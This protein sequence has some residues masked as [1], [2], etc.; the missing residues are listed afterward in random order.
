MVS[1]HVFVGAGLCGAADL[2]SVHLPRGYSCVLQ[3]EGACRSAGPAQT[4]RW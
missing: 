4:A 3:G 1:E 2:K